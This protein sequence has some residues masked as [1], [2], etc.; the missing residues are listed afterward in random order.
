MDIQNDLTVT[1]KNLM[2]TEPFYGL[3]LLNLINT[4]Q[5]FNKKK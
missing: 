2:F 4:I 3:L 5:F 1:C